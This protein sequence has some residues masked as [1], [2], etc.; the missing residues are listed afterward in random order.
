MS[1]RLVLIASTPRVGSTL[2]ADQLSQAGFGA[3]AEYF[4]PFN[5]IGPRSKTLNAES[6]EE[7]WNAIKS[8]TCE[9]KTILV[10]AHFEH[11]SYF[12]NKYNF[13]L[14]PDIASVHYI[15][16]RRRNR[17]RQAIS[18]VLA[19]YSGKWN[20]TQTGEK[21][22]SNLY[23]LTKEQILIYTRIYMTNLYVRDA[24]WAEY[25]DLKG[26][27][28]YTLYYEDLVKGTTLPGWC[29]G[30]PEDIPLNPKSSRLSATSGNINEAM[31]SVYREMEKKDTMVHS[32]EIYK[33]ALIGALPFFDTA[34]VQHF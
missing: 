3:G 20:S 11:F 22:A 19:R 18:Y 15:W 33:N 1:L 17:A 21:N 28:P 32:P 4:N 10:K 16:M 5:D 24:M 9:N 26:I 6:Y 23:D 30:S 12:I 14:D 29:V 7:Y 13:L 34:R 25:F 31:Y 2:L 8:K 27:N